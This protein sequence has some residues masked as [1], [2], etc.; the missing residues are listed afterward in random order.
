MICY[1]VILNCRY[2]NN[3]IRMKSARMA[4][5]LQDP[6]GGIRTVFIAIRCLDVYIVVVE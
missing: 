6:G 3:D 5:H 2:N 4:M 1:L